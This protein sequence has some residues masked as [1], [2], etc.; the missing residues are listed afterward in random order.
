[1][2]LFPGTTRVGQ[3]NHN[4]STR[5]PKRVRLLVEELESRLTPTGGTKPALSVLSAG[6]TGASAATIVAT[7][8]QTLTSILLSPSSVILADKGQQQFK[9]TAYDQNGLTMATQ[10]AFTWS[11]ASGSLGQINSSGAYTGP[12]SGSGSATVRATAAGL[13]GTASVSIQPLP[14]VITQQAGANANPVTG[15]QTTLSVNASDPNGST[16]SYSWTVSSQPA[17]S[18]TPTFDNASSSQPKATFYQPGSY[19]FTVAVK[20][21]LGL[22]A[23][24]SVTVSVVQTP[25]GLSITPAKVTVG[26]GSTTVFSAAA[27]DQFHNPMPTQPSFTWQVTGGTL[28]STTGSSVTF[29]AGGVGNGTVKVSNGNLSAQASITVTTPPAAPTNLQA[30]IQSGQIKL[31]WTLNSNNQTGFV[32]QYLPCCIPNPQWTTL[33]TVASTGNN[34][35][36]T[37]PANLGPTVQYQVYETNALGNSPP[38][39]V[40]TVTTPAAAPTGLCATAGKSLVSL[41][42]STST[43]ATSYNVYRAMSSGQEGS[44]PVATGVT[45]LTFADSNVS[46]GTTYYYQ[47]TAVNAAGQS[48]KSSEACAT[49]PQVPAA[50]T[51]LAAAAGV[52]NVGLSWNAVSGATS[53]NV[54]RGTSAGGEAFYLSVTGTSYNDTAVTAFT[55]YYYRVSAVNANGEGALAAEVSGT[56][57]NDWFANNMP[58]PGLQNLARTD[59]TNDGA[60]TYNDMLGILGQAVTEAGTGMMSTA[61]VASLQALASA[62]G[63]TYLNMGASLQGLTQNLVNGSQ[64]PV[65]AALKAGSTTAAQLQNAINL[66]FLGEDLPTI[67]TQYWGTSGYAL[68]NQG[69]LFGG[70]GAPLYTDI[71]QG[72]E[73][74][75]WLMASFAEIAYKQPGII[76]GNFTDDGPVLENGVQVHVWT[77]KFYSGGTPKY[78]TLNNYFPSNSGVF[79]YAD[80]YQT[81]ANTSNVLWGPLMEKAYAV[82][83]GNAYAGLNGGYAQNVL[84]METGGTYAGNNPFGSESSYITAIQSPNTLL[85]LA[86]WSTNY[87]FVAD[88]DYA[89]ISV[90]GSG[91]TALFQLYNPWGTNQPPAITWAQLTQAGDFSQDGDT[92]VFSAAP[93]LAWPG[94]APQG[95]AAGLAGGAS[96]NAGNAWYVAPEFHAPGAGDCPAS[97]VVEITPQFAANSPDTT[98]STLAGP[99][100][101]RD[102]DAPIDPRI[103]LSLFGDLTVD[104]HK[105]AFQMG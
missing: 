51:G 50:P 64:Y 30:S 14:P 94:P 89:V 101:A 20:D 8:G 82:I 38:S 32:V 93:G 57:G 35:T 39:N 80:F 65:T 1:M 9:A 47:V 86:S 41:S 99:D 45:A 105:T 63:A 34:Y 100:A 54:Y 58:D 79:M 3:S 68:A 98:Q 10:P 104:E 40:V 81:I 4:T 85:T 97:Y 91:S 43:G 77:Y 67:D 46:G 37:P 60:I 55:T 6:H 33:A 7:A 29:T 71:Y 25:S 52:S 95:A 22:S 49:T 70:S 103:A 72:E 84:P 42:W 78:M 83:Y 2:Q 21:A 102:S 27:V 12:S 36:F 19:S 23:S 75:C 15:T 87:G 48:S 74:D 24:S 76:E 59:F 44:T 73:G 69:T 62:S 92:V 61:Q 53:Y 31:Q 16:L 26:P 13:T 66:C 56:P 11:L 5:K 18:T 88:H 90:S 17:G 28:S 96:A